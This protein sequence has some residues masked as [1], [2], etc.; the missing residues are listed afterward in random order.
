MF[1]T[2]IPSFVTAVIFQASIGT[3]AQHL[4]PSV[5]SP[6][7]RPTLRIVARALVARLRSGIYERETIAGNK[8]G[9][10]NR[11]RKLLSFNKAEERTPTFTDEFT[12]PK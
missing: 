2:P 4:I 1:A 3:F 10:G 6:P 8:T 5:T 12:L 11:R 9:F 7:D